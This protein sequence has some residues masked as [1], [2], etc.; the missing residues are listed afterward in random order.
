MHPYECSRHICL[1]SLL[2]NGTGFILKMMSSFLGCFLAFMQTISAEKVRIR[3]IHILDKTHKGN[4]LLIF[5]AANERAALNVRFEKSI[6]DTMAVP[7]I[8]T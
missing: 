7:K 4:L 5:H 2:Q 3:I 1:L 6:N 8:S